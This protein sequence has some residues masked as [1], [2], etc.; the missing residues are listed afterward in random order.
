MYIFLF[1]YTYICIQTS[2]GMI[3]KSMIVNHDI[4]NFIRFLI[5]ILNHFLSYDFDFKSFYM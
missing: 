1:V 5:L 3:L 4:I 2:V